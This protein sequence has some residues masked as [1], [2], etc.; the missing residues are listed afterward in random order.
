MVTWSSRNNHICVQ[1]SSVKGDVVVWSPPPWLVLTCLAKTAMCTNF[2]PKGKNSTQKAEADVAINVISDFSYGGNNLH[3][4][5]KTSHKDMV[6]R[7]C[8]SRKSSWSATAYTVISCEHCNR[9]TCFITMRV[10]R[11]ET[12]EFHRSSISPINVEAKLL[13]I[14]RRSSRQ[15]GVNRMTTTITRNPVQV[16]FH[17]VV[18]TD[19]AS[20]VHSRSWQHVMVCATSFGQ[21]NV[22]KFACQD[23][24]FGISNSMEF[25][26]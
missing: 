1:S 22:R 17:D 14:Q 12:L 4:L 10:R 15:G 7:H 11:I 18:L 26:L 13:W 20:P 19:V 9:S 16:A 24:D 3:K 5:C 21:V 23:D 8:S 25:K 2:R 6:V